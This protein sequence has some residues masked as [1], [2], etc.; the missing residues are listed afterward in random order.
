MKR[1][2]NALC[3]IPFHRRPLP[4]AIS[5]LLLGSSAYA[6]TLAPITTQVLNT[7]TP[8]VPIVRV[9]AGDNIV[10]T[11]SRLTT[12][13]NGSSA[14]AVEGTL[15]GSGLILQT[16]GRE[17]QAV[18]ADHGGSVDLEQT[19]ITTNG[20]GAHGLH[21]NGSVSVVRLR[22]GSLSI[23]G[24]TGYGA[25]S[26]N[27]GRVELERASVNTFEEYG[28][29]ANVQDG[30][31]VQVLDSSLNTRGK[32]AHGVMLMGADANDRALATIRNSQI[33]TRGLSA[34][35][36]NLNEAASATIQ[37]SLINT[38][39]EESH[40]I[41]LA[42]PDTDVTLTDVLIGTNG[43]NAAGVANQG[44]T[45]TLKNVTIGT[46]GQ[47][48]HGLYSQGA[49][50]TLDAKNSAITIE[51]SGAG[52]FAVDGGTLTLDTG[53]VTAH[54]SATGLQA[55][56][57]GKLS[58]SHVQ[59]KADGTATRAL[60]V[61]EGAT[62]NLD[63]VQA[64]ATG[65][66]S[67]GL[68]SSASNSSTLNQ[69]SMKD[70]RLSAVQST[71][72]AVRGG[73]LDLTLDNSV[74]EGQQLLDVDADGAVA[75]GR[76]QIEARRSTLLGDIR[77]AGASDGA[78]TLQLRDSTLTG[79]INDLDRLEVL[80]ASRWTLTA[81]SSLGELVNQ[82]TVAFQP[83]GA[84]KTLTVQ[85]LSGNGRFTMNTDLASQQGDLLRVL[86]TISGNHSL[87]VADSGHEP[88][89]PDGK[90]RLVD[91]NGG[92]GTFTLAGRPYVDAG[93][94][95]YRL[96]QDGDDWLLRN[97]G[98]A[99]KPQDNLSSGANA[100]L[101][102]QTAAATL[103]NAEM[104]ALV[105]RLG[106]LRMGHDNGGL[107]S[108]AIGKTYEVDTAHS[109]DFQQAVHGVE[110]GADTAV[111]LSGSKLYVGGV[112]GMATSTQS[113]G[114]GGNGEIDSRVLGAY[115]TWL[116]DSGYYV[117]SVAKYNR[118]NNE[119]KNQANTG[120]QVTGKYTTHGYAG[121]VEIGRHIPLSDGW[122]IEP[123]SEL[124]YTHTAG[125]RYT[126]SNGL[127]VDASDA[128][129]LQGRLGSLLGRRWTL[130]NGMP[131]QP[132]VKASYVHEF[133]GASSVKVNG[134]TLTNRV[135]GSRAEYGLGGVLQVS[136]KTKVALDIQQAKGDQVE[137][138]WALNLGV[139]YLW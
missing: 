42:K 22:G 37:D 89:A 1:S 6:A 101:A 76:V 92:S 117:D 26:L 85:D 99:D 25:S 14:L 67:A 36:V 138:P 10:V 38:D 86:G 134:H 73:Q 80:N 72:I 109:R 54:G 133:A 43:D 93:A 91:G 77:V 39:G 17:A 8:S 104:N 28:M 70:S 114:D 127:R 48:A 136:E 123:Q 49:S 61:S 56:N 33:T 34:V 98:P 119:V 7:D 90:L 84:F 41:W 94:Y 74:V 51:Q 125:A 78:A 132:Y 11:D 24:N 35:G 79:A 128:D 120:E 47:H 139:R 59:V 20:I 23:N 60:L 31:S 45:A 96:Q 116:N 18:E 40:G 3:S 107:W 105:K 95:R 16:Y 108:R 13:A 121:D 131:F 63:D 110:I 126:A 111:Q 130:R 137:E 12:L 68:W 50:A 53:T 30:G 57:T 21:A 118:M 69:V 65:T 29:G 55:A 97:T 75:H 129:S 113:F 122:F 135:A 9:A 115:A 106:E 27:G 66:S 103:W 62:L 83:G 15:S 112:L 4:Y 19:D 81:S 44:G 124:T 58:A 71:A 2:A 52:A 64:S 32:E 46:Y 87:A 82:G 102:S 5:L 100:A 88:S